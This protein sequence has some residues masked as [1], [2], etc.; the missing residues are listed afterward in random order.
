MTTVAWSIRVGVV[1][2]ALVSAGCEH[3]AQDTGL[4]LVSL[5]YG[6]PRSGTREIAP[7]SAIPYKVGTS[8]YGWRLAFEPTPGVVEFEE[9]LTL[10]TPAPNWGSDE[11]TKVASDRA[12]ARTRV[13]ADGRSGNAAHEWCVAE[14]DPEGEYAFTIFRDNARV[15]RVKFR[16]LRQ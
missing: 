7:G 6:D 4:R 2:M 11:W 15:G 13:P 5:Q 14:G 3:G 12:S 8:C 10:P 1:A 16:V 9:V